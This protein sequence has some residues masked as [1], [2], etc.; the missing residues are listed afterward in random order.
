[1]LF[2]MRTHI[3]AFTLFVLAGAFCT[4]ESKGICPS[5]PPKPLLSK[6]MASASATAPTPNGKFLGTV[7]LMATVSNKGFVCS[8]Q[9][10][11]GVDKETDKQAVK[12]MREWHYGPARKDGVPVPVVILVEVEYWRKDGEAAP[13][14]VFHTPQ[15]QSEPATGR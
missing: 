8:A 3:I 2:Q 7:M 12:D 9:V 10:I 14:A 15:A 1:M 11:R 5:S 6:P 13:V 4:A